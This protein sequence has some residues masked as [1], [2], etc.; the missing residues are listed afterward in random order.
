MPVASARR[1][2]RR[3]S[4]WLASR[5]LR[6]PPTRRAGL[7][8]DLAEALALSADRGRLAA[9]LEED[10]PGILGHSSGRLY[11]VSEDGRSLAPARAAEEEG[12]AAVALDAP[13]A[14]RLAASTGPEPLHTL[15][16]AHPAV[17]HALT[18]EGAILAL[19]LVA[20]GA[21]QGLLCLGPRLAGGAPRAGDLAVLRALGHEAALAAHNV[22]LIEALRAEREGLAR[23]HE[24]LL[25]A[26]EEERR[27]LARELHD[28]ALQDILG[29]RYRLA[30]WQAESPEDG[31]AFPERAEAVRSELRRIAEALRGTVRDL[32]PAGPAPE[33]LSAALAGAAAR[34]EEE[35]PGR[36]PPVT[37]D[38]PLSLRLPLPAELCLFRAAKE[39][40]RNVARHADA[41]LVAVRVEEGGG[42]VALTVEDDGR[43][44]APP[45]RLG[46]LARGAHYGLAGLEE[47]VASLGGAL[48]V[49]S[50]P[51]VGTRL[52]VTL[53]IT[54]QEEPD[55]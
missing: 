31:P 11:L 29:L 40:L 27:R 52:T 44:F 32:R 15:A 35:F 16:E 36:L 28:G 2:V 30:E 34:L 10:L 24:A 6:L 49:A 18:H 23:A 55:G 39:A 54:T 14:R 25:M 38:I 12:A 21:V 50:R 48:A 22:R 46:D 13:L 26:R 5:G 45:E 53:P 1:L 33:G 7:V 47:R 17:C 4:S 42:R 19:P 43:G 9:L 51:G 3:A 37:L 8:A 20:D 41:R